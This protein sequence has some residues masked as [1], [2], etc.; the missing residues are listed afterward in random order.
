MAPA[1]LCHVDA[2][3]FYANEGC[4]GTCS[5]HSIYK[6]VKILAIR[7]PALPKDVLNLV[8]DFSQTESVPMKDD[9]ILA[10]L[11]LGKD[12]LIEPRSVD[13]RAL[14]FRHTHHLPVLH[15]DNIRHAMEILNLPADRFL[16]SEDA[17]KLMI[18]IDLRNPERG[19]RIAM[20][21]AIVIKTLHRAALPME[22]FSVGLCY[23][24]RPLCVSTM[25]M[26]TI[27]EIVY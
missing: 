21:K 20:E 10:K 7:W 16:R 2:C 26:D 5:R 27:R 13:E 19:T 8:W 22:M 6:A 9:D 25:H 17:Q 3:P 11:G 4:Y 23:Y 24:G 14:W 1:P 15:C 12:V 18:A